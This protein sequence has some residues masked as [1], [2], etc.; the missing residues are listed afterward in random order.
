MDQAVPFLN[1]PF[2]RPAERAAAAVWPLA[3][4]IFD[5]GFALALIVAM[6]PVLIAIAIA[7]KVDSRGP[8]FHRVRRVGYRGRPLTMLKFRKMHHDATGGPLTTAADPRLTRVGALLTRT[9]L[10]EL[11]QLW[12][13]LCGRMSIVGPRPEDP[14]FVALH[15]DQYEAIHS[16][17]PGITGITQLA[18]AQESRILSA[19][20]PVGD[21]VGRILPNKVQLDVLYANKTRISMDLAVLYWTIAAVVMRRSIAVHRSTGR[22]NSRRR[23]P[24]PR[25]EAVREDGAS[26]TSASSP[27]A[28]GRTARARFGREDLRSACAWRHRWTDRRRGPGPG[29]IER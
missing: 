13:V 7:I 23:P 15:P 14:L 22:M 28:R 8:V 20:D 25:L 12:D 11:P 26:S 9:R 2:D 10:D 27:A 18:F 24:A 6:L 5:A 4:R 17:R 21:Y 1:L 16:V 29:R 3:K 19:E